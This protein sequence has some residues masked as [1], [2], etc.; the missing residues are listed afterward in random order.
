VDHHQH[1]GG[2]LFYRDA[3]PS[4]L[5]GQFGLGYRDAVLDEH[6]RDVEVGAEREGDG[7][8]QIAVGGRLAVHVEH[9][10]DAVDLLLERRRHRIADNFS[11]SA[12]ITGGD[13]NRGRR[14]L[15]VLGHRQRE[16]GG[17]AN[18][19]DKDRQDGRKDRPVDKEMRNIHR[20][21]PLRCANSATVNAEPPS[22]SVPVAR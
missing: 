2:V 10:L 18:N 16:I 1:V 15:R 4:H 7:E 17:R 20:V 6:L 12:G 9:I 22:R 5:L 19:D 21:R 11:G 8:L 14:D 13:D 3:E